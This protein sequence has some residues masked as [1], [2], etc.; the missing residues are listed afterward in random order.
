MATQEKKSPEGEVESNTTK[1]ELS[2]TI[3]TN[4]VSTDPAN[5]PRK[6]TMGRILSYA[7]TSHKW[8][9]G[10]TAFISALNGSLL[11]VMNIVFGTI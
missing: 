5:G 6:V 11:P 10:G 9:L 7:P 2:A 1:P 8:V 4:D 3:T